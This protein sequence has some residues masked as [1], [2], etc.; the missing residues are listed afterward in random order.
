LE[1]RSI[2]FI[3][4]VYHVVQSFPEESLKSYLII[5]KQ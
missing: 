1:V 2:Y 4:K 3:P 5:I